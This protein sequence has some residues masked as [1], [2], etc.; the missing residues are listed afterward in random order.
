MKIIDLRSDTVT[1]PTPEMKKAMCDAPLGDDVFGE[2]PTVNSLEEMAAVKTGKE[3]ALFTPSGTMSNLLAVLSQTRPGDEIILGSESHILW[4]EVGGA[5][6]VGGVVM[7][8]VPNQPD[9]TIHL[10]DIK[11]AIRSSNLHFPPTR[12]ICLEN[13]HNRCGGAVLSLSYT[14]GVAN[15]AGARGIKVHL[16]G[17]RL[18]NACVALGVS[19]KELCLG[20]DTVSFCLS[21][22]LSAPAGSLLCS[23]RETI[24]RARKFRKMLGGGMRQA[25]VLAACGIVALETMID[26]LAQDHAMAKTLAE[27]LFSIDNHTLDKNTVQTNIVIFNPPFG[28]DADKFLVQAKQAGMLFTTGS[29]GR[30]RAVCHHDLS[31]SDIQTAL[32]RIAAMKGC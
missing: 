32:S 24:N 4:Y 23:D 27:G 11:D 16:D 12:L 29:H 18:F 19:A 7:R 31:E 30:V 1:R 6:A 15:L 25:G 10:A 5:S 14:A 3:A 17:A 28:L 13:T 22:G 2:D 8:A 26:R 20:M 9:G 21:K